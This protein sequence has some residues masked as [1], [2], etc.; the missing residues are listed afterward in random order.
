M[1][2]EECILDIAGSSIENRGIQSKKVIK[3]QFI[4]TEMHVL[5]RERLGTKRNG[6]FIWDEIIELIEQKKGKAALRM[7]KKSL[8]S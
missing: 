7:F 3:Y 8:K 2:G 4:D 5:L 6:E 1:V